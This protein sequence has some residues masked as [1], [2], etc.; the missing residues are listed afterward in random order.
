MR[1]KTRLSW[2]ALLF[3]CAAFGVGEPV[4]APEVSG[5]ERIA[6]DPAAEFALAR[7]R[8]LDPE[9]AVE[10][11]GKGEETNPA[12]GYTY[13]LV[14]AR[15]GRRDV[16]GVFNATTGE[17]ATD[18]SLPARDVERVVASLP[19]A[20]RKMGWGLLRGARLAQGGKLGGSGGESVVFDV[21]LYARSTKE[22]EAIEAA[23]GGAKFVRFDLPAQFDATPSVVRTSKDGDAPEP[24][25]APQVRAILATLS[26]GDVVRVA[27]L[28]A[29]QHVEIAGRKE[30]RLDVSVPR[31]RANLT[32]GY[33]LRGTTADIGVIDTGVDNTHPD[34]DTPIFGIDLVIAERDF[35][36]DGRLC[37]GGANNGTVC[38]C[39]PGGGCP[40]GVC[41][42]GPLAGSAC[43]AAC[44]GPGVCEGPEDDRSGHGTHVS[45][46][47]INT[48]AALE[49]MA[50]LADVISAKVLAPGG[51]AAGS[52]PT[53]FSGTAWTTAPARGADVLNL[54]LGGPPTPGVSN[55]Q[56]PTSRQVDYEVFVH[57]KSACIA[58][59]EAPNDAAPIAPA[60]A[61][62]V[63]SIGATN[64]TAGAST[65][66]TFQIPG[67][68]TDS[69]SKPDVSAPGESPGAD[70]IDSTAHDWEG[71]NPDFRD[72][73]GT[74]MATPHVAG[75]TAELWDWGTTKGR[76]ADT[77]YL[78]AA[79]LNNAN[80]LAAWARPGFAQP[81]DR[82]QGTGEIDA[83]ETFRAYADDLRVWQQRVTGTDPKDSHWYWL[84]LTGAP[85][86]LVT[87]LAFER[88]VTNSEAVTPGVAA[89]PLNDIDLDLYD[90][91]GSLV[92][93]SSSSVDSVEHIV[94]NAT[95]NG[96]W[97]VE[98]D[99]FDLSQD[100][101]DLYALAASRPPVGNIRDFRLNF[102]GNVKPC[103]PD[104]GDA[105]D[106]FTGPGR[107]PTLLANNGARH[108]DW[109]KEWLGTS[110]PEIDGELR[111]G[112]LAVVSRVDPFPSVSGESDAAD[113]AD[114]DGVVN[115]VDMDF[116][117]DGVFIPGPF[118]P[119]VPKTITM[120][121]ECTVDDT[122][123][124]ALG[125]YD[126]AVATKRLY[127]NGWADWNGD[128][129]WTDPGEKIVGT[130]SPTGQVAIDPATFG[131]N[132]LYTVGESFTDS[133]GSGYWELG[134]PFTDTVGATSKSFPYVVVPPAFIAPDFYLRFR[135]DYG[136]DVGVV[137]NVSGNLV[138]DR[139]AAQ[140]GEVEDYRQ[141]YEI[142]AFPA[143]VAQID[144][145]IPPAST[146]P[147]LVDLTG[148]SVTRV[149]L[150]S[151]ADTDFDG[152][153]QVTTEMTLLSLTGTS[154]TYGDMTV[155]LRPPTSDPFLTTIGE[156]EETSNGTS[157]MLDLSPFVTSPPNL[158]AESFFNV[159]FEV[160]LPTLGITLH[161]HAPKRMKGR[162]YNKP[163][164][165]GDPYASFDFIP[166][167]DQGENLVAVAGP[168]YHI[169]TRPKK[170]VELDLFPLSV[171]RIDLRIPA[172]SPVPNLV[173][174]TGPTAVRVDL[175]LIGDPDFDGLESVSTEMV[176]LELT[177]FQPSVGN[178]TV[179]RRSASEHP[180]QFTIGEIEE[181][182]N[183]T[184]AM[185]DMPPFVN[186]PPDLT[187]DSFFDV[188]FD[189][190]LPTLGLRLHTHQPKRMATTIRHKPPAR[191]DTYQNPNFIPL[192]DSNESIVAEIG[193]G[194]HVPN[195]GC[196]I[197]CID[198]NPCTTDSCDPQT[199]TCIHTPVICNDQDPC[200]T[201]FCSPGSGGCV[202][203]PAP[204]GTS[205]QDGNA[206]TGSDAC[207]G[208]I[209]QPGG[210]LVCSDGNGCTDD[211]C[212]PAVGCVFDENTAACDDGDPCTTGDVCV[213]R[214]CHPGNP[215]PT[216]VYDGGA[217]WANVRFANKTVIVLPPA[218]QTV[219]L[220]R[221]QLAVLRST[222][223]GNYSATNCLANNSNALTFND[224]VNPVLG[225]GLYY[226]FR[227]QGTSACE[228]HRYTTF[229]PRETPTAPDR[230]DDGVSGVLS[231]PP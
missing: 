166:L 63:M 225:S 151:L 127:L 85:R 157:S 34:L 119:L 139:G 106:P 137:A 91:T 86:D 105:P 57:N 42:G 211:S 29:V 196:G 104:F 50:P 115:L 208:G 125:R 23:L 97:C 228:N 99:P 73:E 110:R 136:E 28:D 43:V 221:G 4:A 160:D 145:R 64:L 174:L 150:G 204:D 161:N 149:N 25:E 205:C 223:L 170:P 117:D 180:F 192:F 75:L 24:D 55:G 26:L 1:S 231:C 9:A 37:V 131:T 112:T 200:T 146:T 206:C 68:T 210:P 74:S 165:E 79:I 193:P 132:G 138:Q 158:S 188:F 172:G 178:V 130:G 82:E 8:N 47:A 80:R 33:G 51:A 17:F 142:D 195:P 44:A 111:K 220:A 213:A 123:V 226:L 71:A 134:E 217:W 41:V 219:D 78:K 94:H 147:H 202:S 140:L 11:V 216:G 36:G 102:L 135:I 46:I 184:S 198:S 12:T 159:Y 21:A 87:T 89:P 59:A 120:T 153:E 2:L 124:G 48:S 95:T 189:V 76:L 53:I 5:I 169:P 171:A 10:V 229:S 67:P 66:A 187:A 13:T 214:Q 103:V 16:T 126:A 156:I 201:D 167:Y 54:S 154:P 230:R 182:Q 129:D 224:A 27:A 58:T 32:K 176:H 45:G 62:N 40:A 143:T 60:D 152:L 92:N 22:L 181:T 177:G 199:E 30:A 49:G 56:D 215:V 38:G 15:L 118:F 148:P 227:G 197:V 88:H 39:G 6:G 84:D 114:Q 179:K 98:V 203:Q 168:G 20:Y 155:R 207:V 185:L 194:Y 109:T 144:L 93:I 19:A 113:P 3:C 7:I 70:G 133:N 65:E 175:G 108:L 100:G 183:F 18:R 61:F 141:G 81:L 218:G 162:I 212:D 186:V 14:K 96:R 83:V 163:P 77:P 90:P 101:S 52:D 209:C 121:V 191:G 164:R 173:D 69:R 35:T 72:L 190:D 116:F 222:T 128:G 31:V 107:Y 122:G